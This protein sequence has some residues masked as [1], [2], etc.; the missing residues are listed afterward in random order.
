MRTVLTLVA[1]AA[2]TTTAAAQQLELPRPSPNAKVSQ[3]I[4]VTEVSVDYSSPA[5][6]NRKIWGGVVPYDKVWRAGANSATKITFAKDVVIDG[7]PIAAGSYAFFVQPSAT[8][9]TLILNKDPKQAGIFGYNKADD[10]LRVDVKPQPAPMRERLVY[11]FINFNDAGGSLDLEWEKV[12]VSLP[13]KV[14]TDE[15]VAASV[16]GLMTSGWSPWAQA[17]RYELDKKNVDEGMKLVDT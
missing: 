5:V 10:V 4:G 14:H 13:I 16:K 8:K 11:Q 1:V 6:K 7:K 17:A 3:V 15:Q 9:W 12:R 2:L